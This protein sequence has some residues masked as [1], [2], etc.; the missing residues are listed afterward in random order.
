MS[1]VSVHIAVYH[2]QC[3]WCQDMYQSTAISITGVRTCTSLLLSVSLVSGH[4]P[5]YC[6]HWCQ[7]MYP[8]TAIRHWCHDMYQPTAIS[9][10]CQSMYQSTAISHWCQDMYQSTA[11]SVICVSPCTN[12]LLS[13][14]LVSVHVPVYCY[15][16]CQHMHQPTTVS[17]TSE[18]M[19]PGLAVWSVTL[20]TWPCSE[21]CTSC[22]PCIKSSC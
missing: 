21:L 14:S 12:L 6:Y 7:D 20:C 8:S 22:S 4:V 19:A 17:V 9:Y 3:H 10:W 15:H 11:I 5:V 18:S 2:C 1:L 13:V 16:W